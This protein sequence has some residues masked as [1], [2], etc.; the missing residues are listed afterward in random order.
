MR[1]K[2]QAQHH[3]KHHTNRE[4]D[5]AATSYSKNQQEARHAEQF[6]KRRMSHQI[7]AAGLAQQP[8]YDFST[9]APQPESGEP[10]DLHFKSKY[11]ADRNLR[12]QQDCQAFSN[13]LSKFRQRLQRDNESNEKGHRT[14]DLDDENNND[15]ASNQYNKPSRDEAVQA[16]SSLRRISRDLYDQ[17]G[18]RSRSYER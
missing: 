1:A 4:R 10:S 2:H 8:N 17:N 13:K 7:S 3:T 14:V 6:D 18:E 9:Q 11:A 16:R 15:Y 12:I 5:Y